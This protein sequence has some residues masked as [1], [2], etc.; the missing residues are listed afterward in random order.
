VGLDTQ[1]VFAA[2]AV[3]TVSVKMMADQLEQPVAQLP[4]DNL[5]VPETSKK[6]ATPAHYQTVV[7]AVQP[8]ITNNTAIVT[9][10]ALA[11]PSLP[12]TTDTQPVPESSGHL[13]NLTMQ[14]SSLVLPLSVVL[15]PLVAAERAHDW[16]PVI[17]LVAMSLGILASYG[18]WQR[19]SGHVHAPRGDVA[20]LSFTLAFARDYV[21]ATKQA[22]SLFSLTLPVLAMAGRF[23]ATSCW[24]FG[25]AW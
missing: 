25:R 1:A 16:P 21:A 2:E 12:D 5:V 6:V 7:M 18:L 13:V 22:H 3:E 17:V 23:D 9:D 10:L 4:T 24:K 11:L 20:N 15:Q 19:R 8:V 14:L